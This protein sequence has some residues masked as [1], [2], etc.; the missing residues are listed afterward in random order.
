MG[1]RSPT[2]PDLKVLLS[3]KYHRPHQDHGSVEMATLERHASPGSP[4]G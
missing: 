4:D 3:V 1:T 2:P